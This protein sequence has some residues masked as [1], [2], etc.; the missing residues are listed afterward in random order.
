M[1]ISMF[2]THWSPLI[3]TLNLPGITVGLPVWLF[4]TPIILNALDDAHIRTL[5]QECQ[6]KADP[7]LSSLIVSSP[8]FS[9]S[10]SESVATSTQ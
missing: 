2:W 8:L 3:G 10:S 6:T 7:F 1:L 9:S 4:S 5:F